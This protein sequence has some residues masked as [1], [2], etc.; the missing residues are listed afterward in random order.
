MFVYQLSQINLR[1][2]INFEMVIIMRLTKQHRS[3]FNVFCIMV[4]LTSQKISFA[5]KAS[6]YQN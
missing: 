1:E 3:N 2:S 5:L 4:S 6:T